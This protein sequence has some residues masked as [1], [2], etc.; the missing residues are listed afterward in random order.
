MK[1]HKSTPGI[2]CTVCGKE[3]RVLLGNN[4]N[5]CFKCY[6]GVIKTSKDLA[7]CE[8]CKREIKHKDS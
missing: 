5:L 1:E 7:Y 2:K 4:N 3:A 8:K 6:D